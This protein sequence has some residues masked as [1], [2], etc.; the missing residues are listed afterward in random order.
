MDKPDSSGLEQF[1]Q[2]GIPVL[3]LH[4]PGRKKVSRRQDGTEKVQFRG[5][6]PIHND[7][8]KKKYK[9]SKVV[10]HM[11]KGYNAGVQIPPEIVVID[12][13]PRHFDED[14]DPLARL[15]KDY[16][17]ELDDAPTVRTGSGGYHIYF[18]K[19]ADT[20]VQNGLEGYNGIEFKSHGRQV[21]APGSV[22]PET[23]KH[24]EWAGFAHIADRFPLP[25]NLLECI[26]S[27][28]S[29]TKG[30]PGEY[31]P[32]QIE[33]MLETLDPALFDSNESWEPLMMSVHQASNGQAR[34]EFIAWSTGDPEYSDDAEQ[35]GIRWDSLSISKDGSK[36]GG[37]T[38]RQLVIQYGDKD[39][40]P[41]EKIGE[42]TTADGEAPDL[43][44]DPEVLA[45]V[46][47]KPK[48]SRLEEAISEWYYVNES[49]PIIAHQEFGKGSE[50]DEMVWVTR[51]P[52]AM[53]L[54]WANKPMQ[55]MNGKQITFFDAWSQHPKR[56]DAQ[57]FDFDPTKGRFINKGNGDLRINE[58]RGFRVQPNAGGSWSLLEQMIRDVFCEEGDHIYDYIMDWVAFLFQHP[59]KPAEV[60]LC[61]KGGKGIGKGTLANVILHIC[62]QHGKKLDHPDQLTKNFNSHLHKAV[63]VFAD[64]AMRPYDKAAESKVKSML[65]EPTLLIEPKGR[66]SFSARNYMHLMMASNEDWVAPVDLQ[67]ERRFCVLEGNNTYQG[68]HAFWGALHDE[69]EDGGY[70]AFLHDMMER[71]IEGWRPAQTIPETK[72]LK[73]QRIASLD[74]IER[75]WLSVVKQG[76]FSDPTLV[77]CMTG[78]N[79]HSWGEAAITVPKQ[80]LWEDF[81]RWCLSIK[82]T[83]AGAGRDRKFVTIL[84]G[85]AGAQLDRVSIS[86]AIEAEIPGLILDPS[87]RAKVFTIPHLGACQNLLE[88]KGVWEIDDPE[89]KGDDAWD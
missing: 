23:G 11:E 67:F 62:G 84:K 58:W 21:V 89:A 60:A 14:D 78:E 85:I 12:V 40:I 27:V 5:K 17:I 37:G 59:Q 42:E 81:E 74:L 73:D 70:E 25:S 20:K 88:Q 72:A 30:E 34:E 48:K 29:G 51:K 32:E 49:T 75:W 2:E 87:R 46:H 82:Q 39:T 61:M 1:I 79:G 56:R 54:F 15:A 9:P 55:L 38:L 3:P 64:E 65:T 86:P 47:E 36:R 77:R 28:S 6:T 13:D 71:D 45:N 35:I 7:W 50:G 19:P 53:R 83:A 18:T 8:T 33:T 16:N 44:L 63:F 4:A 10:E 66:D 52:E 69:L 57:G 22:H 76:N 41:R 31:T 24:Y 68:D 43:D 26:E 80:L